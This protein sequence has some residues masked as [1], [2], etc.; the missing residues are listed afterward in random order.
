MTPTQH[1]VWIEQAENAELEDGL[2]FSDIPSDLEQLFSIQRRLEGGTRQER[3]MQREIKR[4]EPVLDQ[5]PTV[6][7]IEGA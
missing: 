2:D 5:M 7:M 4:Q 1:K 3:L 6:R